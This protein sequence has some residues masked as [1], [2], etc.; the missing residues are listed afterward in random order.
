MGNQTK[1]MSTILFNSAL[2]TVQH[3]KVWYCKRKQGDDKTVVKDVLGHL[4]MAVLVDDDGVPV[5]HEG[6][7]IVGLQLDTL[8]APLLMKDQPESGRG[9]IARSG[10][11]FEL[12]VQACK[13]LSWRKEFAEALKSGEFGVFDYPEAKKETLKAQQEAKSKQAKAVKLLQSLDA[14]TLAT[15][16][17]AMQK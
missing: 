2:S 9:T 1:S 7:T 11:D 13:G 5:Q 3:C 10:E 16:L 8:D 12:H 4:P 14:D 6:Y 17:A 15:L